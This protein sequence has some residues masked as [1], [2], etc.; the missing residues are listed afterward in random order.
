MSVL[1]NRGVK[2]W[3]NGSSGT[4]CTDH[5]G[6]RIK[7]EGVKTASLTDLLTSFEKAGLSVVKIE[8]L[9]TLDGKDGFTAAAG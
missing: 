5:F 1:T 6:A 8:N 2:V 3:P 7:G 9:Y 4:F